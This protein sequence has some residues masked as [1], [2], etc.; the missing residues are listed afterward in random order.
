MSEEKITA[1][2]LRELFTKTMPPNIDNM[3][4]LFGLGRLNYSTKQLE[5][6]EDMIDKQYPLGHKPMATTL[7]PF[8]YYLGECII[9]AV[10]GASWYFPPDSDSLSSVSVSLKSGSSSHLVYPFTRV[11]K[12]WR[13][14]TDR[15]STMVRMTQFMAEV[16]LDRKYL[17]TRIGKDGWIQSYYGDCYRMMIADKETMKPTPGKSY[18]QAM[19][20]MGDD[21][22][23]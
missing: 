1:D 14:R 4:K 6:I 11:V 20:E 12:F 8:A 22:E 7:I 3:M 9:R 10:P 18:M 16:S 23:K 19:T 15:M 13:D 21:D 2:M 17:A 5:I